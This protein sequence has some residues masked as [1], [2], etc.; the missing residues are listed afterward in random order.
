[1][2]GGPR[3]TIVG[4]GSNQWT[5]KLVADLANTPSLHCA[6]LVLHDISDANLGRMAAYVEHVAAVR[7]IP[8]T[9]STTTDLGAALDGA[10][11]VVV[12]ISTGGF[13]SMTHDLEIPARY[14]IPQSVGDTVGPGGINRTLRNVPVLV[15][16]AAEM[17]RRC[18]DAW[19]LNLT[20][21]MAQLCRAV[22]R[23]TSIR[24]AG[25]CHETTI[26][27]FFLSL[28]TDV[29]FLD[30]DVTAA[31]VN[32]LTFFTAV[33]AGDVDVLARLR[34]LLDGESDLDAELP[35]ALP[36]GGLGMPPRTRSGPWTKGELLDLNR[37]KLELFRIWGVLPAAGDRHLVEFFP[38]FLQDG[39]ELVDRWGVHLTTVDERRHHEA[40]FSAE[41]DAALA[42]DAVTRM[43]SGETL[44]GVIDSL[45]GGVARNVALNIA[46]RGQVPDLADG[47]CVESVCVVS[48]DGVAPRDIAPLPPPVADHLRRVARSEELTVEAALAGER[49]LVVEAMLAD[50]LA[51]RAGYAAVEAMTD[52]LLGATAPWLPQFATRPQN[53]K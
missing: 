2:R 45:R 13:E 39:P 21:P 14:G 19:L 24:C 25:V 23:T 38:W 53:E 22:E 50:P 31:G 37:V 17:E 15:A 26:I 18:P 20:N 16:I 42:A 28:L 40:R 33:K 3:L 52:D 43:P 44:N 30:L 4:G 34:E 27:S 41:L 36:S 10:E 46:N 35:F 47:V 48:A 49:D 32:H 29:S 6:E 5:P 7:S 9:V 51:S 8:M 12:Q 11:F 1:M